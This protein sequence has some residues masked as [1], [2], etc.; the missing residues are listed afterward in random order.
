MLTFYPVRIDHGLDRR[1]PLYVGH[2]YPS[3]KGMRWSKR[4]ER[5]GLIL[6]IA[7]GWYQLVKN[8]PCAC[9]Y[10]EKEILITSLTRKVKDARIILD[11]FF[12]V[13]KIGYNFNNGNKSPSIITPRRLDNRFI[14]AVEALLNKISFTPGALK[15]SDLYLRSDVYIQKNVEA[16]VLS[17]LR[18]DGRI[19]LIPA[20]EWLLK[21]DLPIQ[22]YFKP[23]GKLQARDTSVWPIK[24][25]EN[26]PGWLRGI[27][28]GP[29]VDIENSY[30]QFV[31]HHLEQKYADRTNI[32]H[33]TY[34]DLLRTDKDKLNFR[35]ELLDLLK[36]DN[37]TVNMKIV[38]RLIMALANG[39]NVTPA[40]MTNGSGASKAVCII[41]ESCSH[42][43]P[44][45]LNI[46]GRRLSKIARQFKMARKDLCIYLLKDKPTRIN[47]KKVFTLYF[48]WE[49][50]A[51]YK[52][53]N[54]LGKV[55]LHLHDAIDGVISDKTD[56]ELIDYIAQKTSIRVSV[57]RFLT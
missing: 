13:S 31:V 8:N 30:S 9:G 38:K 52:I 45:D 20:V 33:L 29:S 27:L 40:L 39:S 23:S 21:Q 17:R 14:I 3:L 41:R 5:Q 19:D 50:D 12:S 36:L 44:T 55:G 18:K 28:F 16:Y 56:N 42:L 34:P 24:A 49:R 10:L 15:K 26:W 53:W 35:L 6:S 25:V 1:N 48:Q 7:V 43:L 46:V 54:A 37:T 4:I 57:D 51:R 22:F 2:F 47:Q 11:Y 32:L